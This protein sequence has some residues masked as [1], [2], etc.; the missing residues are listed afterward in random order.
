MQIL[1]T[2]SDELALSVGLATAD[3]IGSVPCV[4]PQFS[5]TSRCQGEIIGGICT[6]G[7]HLRMSPHCASKSKFEWATCFFRGLVR[8]SNFH[9]AGSRLARLRRDWLGTDS[10]QSLL[11]VAKV[12]YGIA[13]FLLEYDSQATLQ[14]VQIF[15]EGGMILLF[16]RQLFSSW[17]G[18]WSADN[19][20]VESLSLN[21]FIEDSLLLLMKPFPEPCLA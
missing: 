16:T 13:E 14:E 4:F 15:V 7:W 9:R 11:L 17:L 3:D 8:D 12:T 1:P 21:T 5:S 19:D 20:L 18:K 10:H 2:I 6:E